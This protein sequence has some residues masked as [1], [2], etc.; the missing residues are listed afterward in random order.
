[1]DDMGYED[2]PT[3]FGISQ[4]LVVII[5]TIIIISLIA[6]VLFLGV[7]TYSCLVKDKCVIPF[8]F[9]YGRIMAFP[10]AGFGYSSSYS[11]INSHCSVNGVEVNCSEFPGDE[12]FCRN[13]EEV[14]EDD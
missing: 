4:W 6:E 9:G 7:F 3:Y 12:H 11:S 13:K 14:N 10:I 1:M 8:F 2:T 5:I